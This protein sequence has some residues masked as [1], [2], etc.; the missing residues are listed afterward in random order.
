[1]LDPARAT[2]L[3]KRIR[4]LEGGP[5]LLRSEVADL[6]GLSIWQ[7][8]TWARQSAQCQPRRCFRLGGLAAWIYT[9]EEVEAIRRFNEQM[10]RGPGRPAK[11]SPEQ[12]A[13]RT[14][15]LNLMGYHR[16]MAARRERDLDPE[17]AARARAKLAELQAELDAM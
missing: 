17:G 14:A 13:R 16:R 1:M 5:Y 10:R 9:L 4:A 8:R 3:Q 15:V 2:T 7:L 12:R 11:W 6:L